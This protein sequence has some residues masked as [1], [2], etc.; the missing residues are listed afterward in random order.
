MAHG[1]SPA[2]ALLAWDNTLRPGW[3]L[4]AWVEW[5]E[6][7]GRFPPAAAHRITEAFDAHARGAIPHTSLARSVCHLYALGIAGNRVDEIGAL[8]LQ[9]AAQDDVGMFAFVAPLLALLDRHGI[10]VAVISGAPEETLTA[11]RSRLRIGTVLGTVVETRSGV[12]LPRV[13]RNRATA[14]GM[15]AAVRTVQARFRAVLA[16]GGSMS[17]EPLFEAAPVRLVVGNPRL[18]AGD[19]TSSLHVAAAEASVPPELEALLQR[20]AGHARASHSA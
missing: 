12:Y 13:S 20:A 15:Q 2:V 14:E 6:R 19:G 8:A 3:T 11:Y 7:Q 1:S 9:F 5:L 10:D 18:R 16:A 17:D 4:R